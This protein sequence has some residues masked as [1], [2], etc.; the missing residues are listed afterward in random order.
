VLGAVVLGQY[1][2]GY[3]TP[4]DQFLVP[5]AMADVLPAAGRPSPYAATAFVGGG[6]ALLLLD[7]VPARHGWIAALL[8]L[9]PGLCGLTA[10]LAYVFDEGYLRGLTS[11]VGMAVPARSPCSSSAVGLYAARRTGRSCRALSSPGPGGTLAR[12]LAPVL[13]ALPFGIGV[14]ARQSP[15]VTAH[16]SLAVTLATVSAVLG[17]AVLIAITVR[18]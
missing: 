3:G 6:V 14:L 17:V 2:F 16:A 12:R 5:K 10:L 13:L 15:G 7:A 9:L 1:V 8:G 4:L 11:M 18:S